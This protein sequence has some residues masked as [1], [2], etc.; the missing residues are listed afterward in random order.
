MRW[1]E[2]VLVAAVAM[3]AAMA[4][5]VRAE[6]IYDVVWDGTLTEDL[7][8][9][10]F[11]YLSTQTLGSA[12]ASGSGGAGM[13]LP[14]LT[15]DF[16]VDKGFQITLSAPAGQAIRIVPPGPLVNSVIGLTDVFLV[17]VSSAST[18]SGADI[19]GTIDSVVF[20][21]LSGPAPTVAIDSSFLYN[22]GSITPANGQQFS[23]QVILD[24][25]GPITFQSLTMH[26]T[27]PNDMSFAFS[28]FPMASI[29]AQSMGIFTDFSE[30]PVAPGAWVSLVAVPEID[31]ASAGSVM[32]LLL[33]A[34]G[35]LDSRV[36]Q[37]RSV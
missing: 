6:N 34:L 30:T 1:F 5:P 12:S 13:T 8:T 26:F 32:T 36:R 27:A 10:S 25:S 17:R 9:T 3:A 21:G 33:G 24:L 35:I 19:P 20:G 28:G 23:E 14:P 31:P 22:S 15:V 2:R 29:S 37:R 7:T 18:T 11:F 4:A 16:G